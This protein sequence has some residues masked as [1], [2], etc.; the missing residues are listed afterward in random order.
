MPQRPANRA[1]VRVVS[2]CT[3]ALLSI[4]PGTGIAQGQVAY[5]ATRGSSLPDAP[6]PQ[7]ADSRQTDETTSDAQGAA[8]ISGTVLD[9]TGA[10][11]PDAQ[12]SLTLGDGRR[13]R[14]VKSEGNGGFTF[15]RIPAGSYVVTVEAAGFTRFTTKEFTIT[16]QQA[17]LVPEI[18]LAVAG[19]TTSIVVRPTE[20]IAAEQIRAAEKQRF[21]GVFPNFYVSYVPDAAPLTSK[22]KLSLAAHDTF[23]WTSFVGVSVG[24]GFEQASN[25]F[26]GYGQGAAGYGKRWGALFADGRSSDLLGHY[27][28]ASAF[29]QDPRYFYQGTGTKKSRLYHALSSAFVARSDSGKTMPNY[30]YLLGDLTAGALSNAYYPHADRGAN[31]VFI[32]AAIGIGGRAGQAV[33]QEFLAKRLTKNVPESASSQ[34][35]DASEH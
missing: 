16:A 32:N 14:T 22:Q 15:A 33:F 21:I 31:L 26:P 34:P 3:L 19:S 35:N 29:H 8:S 5:S 12:V 18:S 30:S 27:V 1:R 23:D 17:Y 13:L 7:Q 28:F 25:R 9:S 4:L 11:V 24:A 6:T 20:Q 2:A 10:V